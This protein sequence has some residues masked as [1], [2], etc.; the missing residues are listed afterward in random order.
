MTKKQLHCKKT[1]ANN[2]F[3]FHY[4]LLLGLIPTSSLLPLVS[5]LSTARTTATSLSSSAL[6]CSSPSNDNIVSVWDNVVPKSTCQ[7]LHEEAIKLGLGHF[8]FQRRTDDD[9]CNENGEYNVIERVLDSILTQLEEQ[10]KGNNKKEAKTKASKYVEY[11]TRR[12]W[13]H[14]EAHADVDENLAKQ[15]DQQ[16]QKDAFRYPKQGH[17]LYL[18]VGTNVHGPT[19]IFPHIITGGDLKKHKNDDDSDKV[20]LVTVPAVEG[21]LLRFQGNSLHAVPRPTDLW[22][23]SFVKGSP[24]FEPEEEWGR[25]VILFNTWG[26]E[27]PLDVPYDKR[28]EKSDGKDN[29]NTKCRPHEEWKSAFFLSPSSSSLLDNIN[30][31][32]NADDTTNYDSVVEEEEV[33]NIRTKIWLLGNQRRRNHLDR[34]IRLLGSESL[35]EALYQDHVVSKV[36]LDQ[37]PY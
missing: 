13:R 36:T 25:S 34:N 10:E 14:I 27:P 17:V 29:V 1:I 32:C 35:R 20:N 7:S 37:S 24:K 16:Q 15:Q 11:W 22:T 19:C 31:D 12:E 9:D 4:I 6:S 3:S 28:E 30:E 23:L 18:K 21:R 33:R 2:V 26:D 8:I 5:S